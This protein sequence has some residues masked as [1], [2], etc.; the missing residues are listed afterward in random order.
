MRAGMSGDPWLMVMVMMIYAEET[1]EKA[2]GAQLEKDRAG[3]PTGPASP[4]VTPEARAS[5]SSTLVSPGDTRHTGGGN[6]SLAPGRLLAWTCVMAS[7][8]SCPRP[9]IAIMGQ[10]YK[11]PNVVRRVPP[12]LGAIS[13]SKVGSPHRPQL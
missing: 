4:P 6:C 10:G 8:V 2:A 9:C 7:S 12:G 3:S 1:A 5:A 13:M 11:E